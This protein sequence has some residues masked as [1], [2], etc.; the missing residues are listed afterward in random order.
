MSVEQIKDYIGVDSLSYVTLDGLY[1]ALR[2]PG[3]DESAK[4][5]GA[6]QQSNVQMVTLMTKLDTTL[7][8]INEKLAK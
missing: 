8:K 6:I 3:R 4:A 5:L 7:T 1:R 2:Q